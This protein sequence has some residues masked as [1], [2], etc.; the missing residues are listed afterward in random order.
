MTIPLV[1]ELVVETTPPALTL[2]QE[3]ISLLR[4]FEPVLR[5]TRGEQ[6]F[7]MDVKRYIEDS[8]LWMQ[9]PGYAPVC[10]V[11]EGALNLDLLARFNYARPEAVY[12]LKFIDPLNL[13]ELAAYEVRRVGR[14]LLSRH[15]E[16][17]FH[18]GLGRLARVGYLSRFVDALFTLSLLTRGN[19]PGDTAAAAARAYAQLQSTAESYRYH[20]RVLHRDGWLILQYWFFY[21]FNNWRSGFFGVN[22]HEADWEMI[23]LYLDEPQP[24]DVHPEWVAYA[25]HDASGDDLRRR[26]DDPEMC[27]VGEHPVI[28]VGAG[29]HASYFSPGEYMAELEMHFLRPFA[30]LME[31]LQ[32]RWRKARDEVYSEGTVASPGDIVLESGPHDAPGSALDIFR[33]PFV[34]YARGDGAAIGPEQPKAWAEPVLLEPVP[35]WASNYRGLWGLYAR[36][37]IAGENAPAGPLYNRDGTLRRAWYD[38]LGWAGL[39]KIPPSHLA[40]ARLSQR[41]AAIGERRAASL[42]EI[43]AKST[44]LTELGVEIAAL[45]EHPHLLPE[46]LA[47][48]ERAKALSIELARLRQQAETDVEVLDALDQHRTALAAGQRGPLRA[49]IH[50]AHHPAT[51]S[52]RR[53]NRIAELWAATSIGGLL[54]GVVLLAL[55]SPQH[56]VAGLILLLTAFVFIEAGFRRQMGRLVSSITIVLALIAAGVILYE[57]F[58]QLIVVAVVLIGIYLTWENLREL[59]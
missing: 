28:Y 19:V 30:R 38:P 6:F 36:D 25:S 56:V 3:D 4:R 21:A 20:G 11:P 32:H 14:G 10:L 43:A 1:P 51:A 31:W 35:D 8:S 18:A 41:Y 54:L 40:L 48:Q 44:E 52:E 24:G 12:F 53:M 39:D 22:D 50:R 33:V 37:P 55:F 49:H 13:A 29:S 17:V 9:R 42:A 47:H 34:D 46:A 15:A 45:Y 23:T 27:K 2:E 26:W 7:P 59:L 5:F 57:F 58:W 16:D